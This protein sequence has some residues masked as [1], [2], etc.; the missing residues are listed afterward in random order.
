MVDGM[1]NLTQQVKMCKE[2]VGASYVL[3]LWEKDEC[4]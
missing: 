2:I 4:S 1:H 3:P